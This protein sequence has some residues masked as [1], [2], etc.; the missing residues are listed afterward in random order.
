MYVV[1][2]LVPAS[3]TTRCPLRSNVNPNGTG[4]AEGF[5]VGADSAPDGPTENTSM[6]LPL[7]LV[8]TI[9]WLPAGV[10]PI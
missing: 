1:T 7:A 9:N 8:V 3:V 5:T 6:A 2:A 10:K 4:V